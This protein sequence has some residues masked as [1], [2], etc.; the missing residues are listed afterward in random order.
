[1]K[2]MN[3]R[4][5]FSLKNKHAV[6]TGGAGFLGSRF[7]EA[8]A[9]SGAHV[10]VVDRDRTRAEALARR[11]RLRY[12]TKALAVYGDVSRPEGARAIAAR[13]RRAFGGVQVLLN[14]AATKTARP[15]D[16]F[17]PL[18]T[19]KC[20]AWRRIMSVNLDGM[21]YVAQAFEPLLTEGASVIQTS[22][23]Y[24]IMAP[25]Q[26]IY[27]SESGRARRIHMPAV[28]SASKAGVIGLT[29]YLA[30]Y[31]AGRG[32]R[33]NA[34]TPGG[35]RDGQDQEFQRKYSRRV[36]LGR[37]AEPWEMAGA[38]IYLASDASS[39]VTGH[40]LIVDGGLHVW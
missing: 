23:I 40:N 16:F 9:E 39:Y 14:N 15:G 34:I 24:G 20:G 38:V 5:L 26:R 8:L 22:S 1:M 37:M 33:V 12:G 36:P 13:V 18:R 2:R 25:D 32:I 21:F 28:Y 3:Y 27:E 30:A 31:W 4:R 7:C 19:F 6:V 11:L 35:V 29:R 17:E 10:A